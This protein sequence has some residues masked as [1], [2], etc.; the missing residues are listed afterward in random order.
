MRRSTVLTLVL[1]RSWSTTTVAGWDS[2]PPAPASGLTHEIGFYAGRS[3]SP[4]EI[5]RDV[6]RAGGDTLV[7]R[8]GDS[9]ISG[10]RFELHN[11]FV[12]I[13]FNLFAWLKPVTV[14]SE[15]GVAFPHHGEPPGLYLLEARLYPLGESA[16]A[17]VSPYVG[18]GFGGAF[19]SVDL[20]NVNDQELRHLWVRSF[21][22]GVKLMFNDGE[23]FLDVQFKPCFLSGRDPIAPFTARAVA[24]GIGGRY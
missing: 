1:L 22:A 10:L 21:S 17:R 3:L 5:G 14:E 18:A 15:A 19:I 13:A 7:A 20:D 16:G 6:N 11:R 23:T 12:G 24:I 4:L 8:L 9:A 2:L